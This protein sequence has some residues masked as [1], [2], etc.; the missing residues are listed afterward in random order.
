MVA[1]SVLAR[2]F[3]L[4]VLLHR[5]NVMPT[6]ESILLEK[7]SDIIAV[8]DSTTVRD[9]VAKMAEANVGCLLVE[10]NDKAIGI[11]TER[12]LLRRVV[13]EGKNPDSTMISEVMSSPVSSCKPSDD[14]EECF[15]ILSSK[16]FRHLLVLD[17]EEP[18]GVISLRDVSLVLNKEE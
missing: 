3:S 13:G 18:V 6:V 7:G 1:G 12:D 2:A 16:N 11:F 9:A 4:I 14:V 10:T 8:P 5:N 15:K 17:N